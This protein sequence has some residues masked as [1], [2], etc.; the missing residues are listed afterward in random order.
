MDCLRG[1]KSKHKKEFSFTDMIVFKENSAFSGFWYGV[2]ITCCIISSYLYAYLGAF[3]S[4]SITKER[5]IVVLVF[6]VVFV[7]S[8]LKNFLTEYKSE[9]ISSKP[10]RDLKKIGIRYL[11]NGFIMDFLMI[12]PF[13]PVLSSLSKYVKIAY[14]IKVYRLVK[15]IN[16]FNVSVLIGKI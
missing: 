13:A 14:F 11:N 16:I 8:M 1:K 15:G 12:I 3:G 7:C 6:E 9:T 4:D 10:V 5:D 2:D